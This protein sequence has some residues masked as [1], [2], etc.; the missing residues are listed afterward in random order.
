MKTK[1]IIIKTDFKS[2]YISREA[3]ERLRLIILD[4]HKNNIITEI[5]FT[6]T[7]IASTS[8]FD[9]SIAKLVLEEWTK[10]Q[11]DTFVTLKDINPLDLNV[12]NKIREY[13]KI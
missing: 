11:L 6:D 13:R 2:D 4:N 7:V 9:E 10:E 12:L 1:T 8:F 5:D 3:G